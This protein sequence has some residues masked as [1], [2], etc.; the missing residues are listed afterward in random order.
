MAVM[1]F[2]ADGLRA[3]YSERRLLRASGVV[4]AVA[5][6][7][8]LLSGSPVI[9]I[10]GFAVIGAGLAMV[11]P[12]LFGAASRVPGTTPAAAIAAVSSIGYSGFMVGPPLIGGIAQ[13]ASLTAA[14]VVVIVAASIL[15]L[16][17]HYV[18][19]KQPDGVAGQPL[20]A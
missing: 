16:S 12:I 11:V 5:M 14:L 20:P 1:R 2:I 18:P 4:T 9:S 3:R 8:V 6:A 17:A 15:A 7:I 13:H 19:E 10:L